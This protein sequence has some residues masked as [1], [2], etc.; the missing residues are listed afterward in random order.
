[1]T[2]LCVWFSSMI[3]GDLWL[4]S[5]PRVDTLLLGSFV[6]GTGTET[7][8][9]FRR[10]DLYRELRYRTCTQG[11][12]LQ[13]PPKTRIL[14]MTSNANSGSCVPY[15]TGTALIPHLNILNILIPP[16]RI[17]YPWTKLTAHQVRGEISAMTT[18][19]PTNPKIL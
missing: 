6:F 12:I 1:M 16:E 9:R 8:G 2:F 7:V 18:T 17:Y 5:S 4:L 13:H 14:R 11:S 19:P 15:S 10:V 3:V